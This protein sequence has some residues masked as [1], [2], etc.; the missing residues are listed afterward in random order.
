MEEHITETLPLPLSKMPLHLGSGFACSLSPNAGALPHWIGYWKQHAVPHT[1]FDFLQV[2]LLIFRLFKISLCNH[3]YVPG[4][5]SR[6]SFASWWQ[7]ESA[8]CPFKAVPPT[9][10]D[11]LSDLLVRLPTGSDS[12]L[13]ASWSP[14]KYQCKLPKSVTGTLRL[15]SRA[16]LL[17]SQVGPIALGLECNFSLGWIILALNLARRLSHC[18]HTPVLSQENEWASHACTSCQRQQFDLKALY[19]QRDL[20]PPP[21]F[22]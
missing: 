4:E 5:S 9:S 6:L 22:G 19:A 8:V 2:C 7:T 11:L 3:T 15:C 18:H 21:P 16:S 13:C 20:E 12:L 14:A 10:P 17:H 1:A